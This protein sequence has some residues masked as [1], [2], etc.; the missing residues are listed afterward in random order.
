LCSTPLPFYA[1]NVLKP[2]TKLVTKVECPLIARCPFFSDRLVNM[3]AVANL[4]KNNYCRTSTHKDCARYRVASK[5]G[6]KHVPADLFPD[7]LVRVD[8]VLRSAGVRP[9][10]R[11]RR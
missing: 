1:L 9:S 11:S 5:I 10:S 7:Q 4:A 3:P 6:S 2:V 8:A